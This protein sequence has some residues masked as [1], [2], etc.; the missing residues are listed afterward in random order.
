MRSIQPTIAGFEDGRRG[1]GAKEC[2]QLLGA[3]KAKGISSPLQLPERNI[4]LPGQN[5]DIL[6][7]AL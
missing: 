2:K 4:V 1:P 3:G 6:L 7:L 5:E